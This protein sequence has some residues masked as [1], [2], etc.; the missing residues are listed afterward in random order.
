MTDFET[1]LLITLIAGG[2]YFSLTLIALIAY[3]QGSHLPIEELFVILFWAFMNIG[4]VLTIWK[5][6]AFKI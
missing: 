5:A 1:K 6:N 2:I 4:L 3:L